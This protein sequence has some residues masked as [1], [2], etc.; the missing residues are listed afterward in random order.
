MIKGATAMAQY[1]VQ[2]SYTPEAWAHMVDNPQNRQELVRPAVES[3][4]GKFDHCWMC[5]GEYDL[6]GIVELPGNVDAGA[7]SIGVSAKGAVRAIKTTP[8][9]TMDESVQMMRRASQLAYAPPQG[10]TAGVR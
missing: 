10:Q 5:F 4:G 2:V 7:F 9:L 6:V 3:L 8:L 1:L